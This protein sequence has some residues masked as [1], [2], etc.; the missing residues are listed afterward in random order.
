MGISRSPVREAIRRLQQDGLV[1][2]RPR[3]GVFVSSVPDAAEIDALYRIRGA[4]EGV[5][6]SLATERATRQDLAT[7]EALMKRGQRAV[8]ADD[9]KSVIEISA[10]FHQTIHAAA[11]SQRLFALLQQIY[12]QVLHLRSY[13]LR[14]PGRASEA[15]QAHAY[16]LEQLKKGDPAATEEAMRAHVNRVRIA[17]LSKI[18]SGEPDW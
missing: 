18:Q 5:A 16:L 10:D 2:I 3:T 14:M 1:E 11:Q 9:S 17:L 4:L 6:A 8:E 12:G 7:L 13:T 15:M